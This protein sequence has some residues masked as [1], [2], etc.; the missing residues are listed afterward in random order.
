MIWVSFG[1]NG[2]LQKFKI[3]TE[4]NIIEEISKLSVNSIGDLLEKADAIN[5]L[6]EIDDS[7]KLMGIVS[8]G[9]G[10]GSPINV[11]RKNINNFLI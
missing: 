10:R 4:K 2:Q 3:I 5:K 9:Y 7:L 11:G 1:K 8:L 6:L